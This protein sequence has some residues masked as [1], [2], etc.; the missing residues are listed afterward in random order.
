[1]HRFLYSWRY[2]NA[3]RKK[4]ERSFSFQSDDRWLL[5]W[6]L[7]LN[8]VMCC[9]WSTL[10][11]RASPFTEPP[12]DGSHHNQTQMEAAAL[13]IVLC[14]LICLSATD[15]RSIKSLL[16]ASW[17]QIFFFLEVGTKLLLYPLST[18]KYK[19][20][21]TAQRHLQH[22]DATCKQITSANIY[23]SKY[24]LPS[25]QAGSSLSK[26]VLLWRVL[27]HAVLVSAKSTQI[28]VIKRS[29]SVERASSVLSHKLPPVSTMCSHCLLAVRDGAG[30]KVSRLLSSF[31]KGC[32]S[33]D[34]E[35][36][37]TN[38]CSLCRHQLDP[39]IPRTASHRAGQ[40]TKV[41]V[42]WSRHS[43]ESWPC[44]HCGFWVSHI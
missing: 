21:I 26:Y 35:T 22:H 16:C 12:E 3:T 10:W 28:R 27:S 5:S 14:S 41:C 11:N 38:C 19:W 31:I 30:L 40:N 29:S 42:R 13:S 36:N 6:H 34:R 25:W 18:V 1:M 33:M 9:I 23:K 32:N 20:S 7:L 8:T 17:R 15:R 24:Q 2:L 44:V 37:M 4:M 39:F 43:M